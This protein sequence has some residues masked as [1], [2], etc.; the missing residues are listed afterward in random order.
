GGNLSTA[1]A[2]RS[3][4]CPA[5]KSVPGGPGLPSSVPSVGHND[6]DAL[7]AFVRFP[8][9]SVPAASLCVGGQSRADAAP[10]GTRE[11]ESGVVTTEPTLRSLRAPPGLPSPCTRVARHPQSP[12]TLQHLDEGT[13]LSAGPWGNPSAPV[14]CTSFGD[15]DAALLAALGVIPPV[16]HTQQSPIDIVR[17][18]S[19]E[20][21]DFLSFGPPRLP[22]NIGCSP[23]GQL[24]SPLGSAGNTPLQKTAQEAARS[25]AEAVAALS[26]ASA[27]KT[28]HTS[29]E[30]VAGEVE[31][32]G[33]GQ[34]LGNREAAALFDV[35][36]TALGLAENSGQQRE[37]SG[38]TKDKVWSR[39]V[40]PSSRL[41]H[42][43]DHQADD[44]QPSSAAGKEGLSDLGARGKAALGPAVPGQ[45]SHFHTGAGGVSMPH[46][47]S[48]VRDNQ[49]TRPSYTVPSVPRA[50]TN[51]GSDPSS[52]ASL[53]SPLFNAG[54]FASLLAQALQQ[55]QEREQ[56]RQLVHDL[57]AR[58]LQEISCQDRSPTKGETSRLQQHTSSSGVSGSGCS[59][60]L[61]LLLA[62]AQERLRLAEQ[63]RAHT[64]SQDRPPVEPSTLS[65]R[66][67]LSSEV[68]RVPEDS[69]S[70]R[71][72]EYFFRR[73]S[74]QQQ[75]HASTAPPPEPL[76]C[77]EG[78][79]KKI[80]RQSRGQQ[81]VSQHQ[82]R[83]HT[84][85]AGSG[86]SSEADTGGRGGRG[87]DM[88]SSSDIAGPAF[89]SVA[90]GSSASVVDS[91]SSTGQAAVVATGPGG[92][93][94][95]PGGAV[96]AT[97]GATGV[98]DRRPRKKRDGRRARGAGGGIGVPEGLDASS[99]PLPSSCSM[100]LRAFRLGTLRPFTLRDVGD[101]ALEFCKDPFASTFLQ[102]QLEVC[103][104]ND[105]MAMLL[106]LLPH[107][108][109][110]TAD[111][112]GSYVLQ[113]FL[114]HGSDKEKEW[115][116]AQLAGDVVRF[117]LEV[118]GC[119]VIQ[120]ALES[121]PLPAQLRLVA[122]LEDHVIACVEDQH[123]NHVIQKCAEQ[124]PPPSVQFIIDAFKGQEAR[125]AVHSYG[126]RV[127]QRLLEA[128]PVAQVA[129]LVDAVMQELRTLI[130]NQFGNYVVQ[131]ILEFGR[132][133]DK[134]K[135]IKLMCESIVPLS[136]EKY[137]WWVK[138]DLN[139][140][141]RALTLDAMGIARR[142]IISA[143]LGGAESSG[144]PLKIMMLD[145]YGNYVVQRM[146]DVAPSDLRPSLLSL[147]RQQVDV[148]KKFTYGKHI[149]TA[150]DRI[151][152]NTS[153]PST[154]SATGPSSATGAP[155]PFTPTG[156]G[157]LPGT[158]VAG[159]GAPGKTS[160][161]SAPPPPV[162]RSNAVNAGSGSAQAQQPAGGQRH[163]YHRAQPQQQQTLPVH[164][165]SDTGSQSVSPSALSPAASGSV[166]SRGG[167]EF[168]AGAAVGWGRRG[169]GQHFQCRN[170]LTG[171]GSPQAATGVAKGGRA[172]TEARPTGFDRQVGGGGGGAAEFIAEDRRLSGSR[173]RADEAHAEW[174]N[175]ARLQ[176]LLQ[177]DHLSPSAR[178][179]ALAALQQC[180]G[181]LSGI[182][183]SSSSSTSP[184]S[185]FS[186]AA[187]GGVG[188]VEN[189]GM[190]QMKNYADSEL[191]R[192]LSQVSTPT[193]RSVLENLGAS[194]GLGAGV[195]G[196]GDNQEGP[197]FVR[198]HTSGG[199]TSS[200]SAVSGS[201]PVQLLPYLSFP[202]ASQPVR[203][204]AMDA[205]GGQPALPHIRQHG[206]FSQLQ[207]L[208]YESSSTS[209]RSLNRAAS[210]GFLYGRGAAGSGS[211][212]A[213]GAVV[214][215]GSGEH[216][217]THQREGS[218]ASGGIRLTPEM[219]SEVLNV[220]QQYQR[221]P[222]PSTPWSRERDGSAAA[223]SPP[224]NPTN[225]RRPP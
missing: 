71:K 30:R 188:D 72:P 203:G 15:T 25:S 187:G 59:E 139:V 223:P 38:S 51:A 160:G 58:C 81:H 27:T 19:G 197:S 119:R 177:I 117:S 140:V 1:A 57:L 62:T 198:A 118:Y 93:P 4:S 173:G 161:T 49:V 207:Y 82:R 114:L 75:Q 83:Q 98:G 209:F 74:F 70:S 100:A 76:P 172:T 201:S 189:T 131:H 111:P 66:G 32:L 12:T 210:S 123:G 150:L 224:Q 18:H 136:T 153:S 157:G 110:L 14:A 109:E 16:S 142:D 91:C 13:S 88:S 24:T 144:Q 41:R 180:L 69:L 112:N 126:C 220:V 214:R 40:H 125:M 186:P 213:P 135:I 7:H 146:M 127:I 175:P 50:S 165:G 22:A 20:P 67:A 221:H 190:H 122:E 204:G 9:L 55:H 145:R 107:V 95:P 37:W 43:Q 128:C 130:R 134:L 36:V 29:A 149:V 78:G 147:L 133:A 39:P 116:A 63:R 215:S 170:L 115:I 85:A 52:P 42:A 65:P 143:A 155:E 113:K 176:Q 219:V 99:A 120:R 80:G 26:G 132:E 61:C 21:P 33:G 181:S 222:A 103:S 171:G 53:P 164:L 2:G 202:G 195:I 28:E 90:G 87:V 73:L 158:T 129:P 206:G 84:A 154:D 156:R 182:S 35:L 46:S 141:E 96:A 124:L 159:A 138:Q 218:S 208:P 185:R 68:S 183:P 8:D 97:S 94:G 199:G 79:T 151:D 48:H 196:A 3:S 5:A 192:C 106:Q 200:A 148:L 121:L 162:S 108:R 89:T 10:P 211:A 34:L 47:P 216:C 212:S 101:N 44:P 60:E 56:H 225:P 191:L 17:E 6:R 11:K 31:T 86:R 184:S 54:D 105:R 163:Q 174:L 169:G 77:G 45:S 194:H 104:V 102:E 92:V 137:S 166:R 193:S 217:S 152:S 205:P 179:S 23:S 167:N 178:A 64:S 168:G